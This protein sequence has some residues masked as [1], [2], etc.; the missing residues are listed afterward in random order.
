MAAKSGI[1]TG[2]DGL[3]VHRPG[4]AD[5][6]ELTGDVDLVGAW[7][8]PVGDG[9]GESGCSSDVDRGLT[10]DILAGEHGRVTRG[11]HLDVLLETDL[12]LKLVP[13]SQGVRE[14]H[15][16]GRWLAT[17]GERHCHQGDKRKK[18]LHTDTLSVTP[19]LTLSG[20]P[21]CTVPPS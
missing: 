21:G 18:T 13:G 1:S 8:R 4:D 7:L 6:G 15:G 19:A 10:R 9:V 2:V 5:V 11:G 17:G 3:S 12:V 20:N 16:L 14:L